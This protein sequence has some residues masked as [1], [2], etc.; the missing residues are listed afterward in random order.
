M[1]ASEDKL[2]VALTWLKLGAELLPVLPGSKH[3]ARNWGSC[4]RRIS[5]PAEA[6]QFFG[7]G[8]SFNL[9]LALV[10][11]WIAAD[12]DDAKAFIDWTHGAGCN[13]PATYMETTGRGAHVVFR[14]AGDV[15][16]G[17]MP[18]SP[19][20]VA[21]MTSGYIVLAP[22]LHPSGKLYTV[23]AD[24]E[25]AYLSIDRAL[26]LCPVLAPKPSCTP[27]LPKAPFT[28]FSKV[29]AIKA[30][31]DLVAELTAAGATGWTQTG[32]A[33]LAHCAWHHPDRHP[34][35]WVLPEKRIWG[36]NTVS[37][38]AFGK[39]DVINARALRVGCTTKEAIAQ[40]WAELHP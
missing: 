4:Q 32:Q 37:C 23:L 7:P 26:Q 20:P 40:L 10:N 21:L 28:G 34:S 24:V 15:R 25:P 22:S 11:G 19:P 14:T 13:C 1:F 29:E 17:A 2:A 8:K 30:E 38:P 33:L 16:A 36:C 31:V 39:H 3:I 18:G 6:R 27:H 5:T 35:L 12:Y 9:G